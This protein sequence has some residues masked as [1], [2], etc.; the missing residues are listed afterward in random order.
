LNTTLSFFKREAVSLLL[1]QVAND[2]GRYRQLG[3]IAISR[4]FPTA[5]ASKI[6]LIAEA[7][8]ERSV[9]APEFDTPKWGPLGIADVN[10]LY[11]SLSGLAS[12]HS[13]RLAQTATI[14]PLGCSRKMRPFGISRPGGKRFRRALALAHDIVGFQSH[15]A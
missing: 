13:G 2:N 15:H 3:E 14:R 9:S 5:T 6:S 12:G 11:H 10:V 1:I 7:L 8:C 4:T